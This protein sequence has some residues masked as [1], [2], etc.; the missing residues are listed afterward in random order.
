MLKKS[1]K[2][3]KNRNLTN[4]QLNVL[5]EINSSKLKETVKEEDLIGRVPWYF[6][7]FIGD[8]NDQMKD[9]NDDIEEKTNFLNQMIE[10]KTNEW[11]FLFKAE[12]IYNKI[13]ET[14][15]FCIPFIKSENRYINFS[16]EH[17]IEKE[18]KNYF[19]YVLPLYSN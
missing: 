4:G 17:H 10:Y 8:K 1:V 13:N 3:F 11:I 14:V 2:L 6:R 7:K 5:K 9:F 19:D 15:E 18:D 12:K 16:T